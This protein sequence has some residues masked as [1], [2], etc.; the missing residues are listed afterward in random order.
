MVNVVKDYIPGWGF[1]EHVVED[2]LVA[3]RFHDP[4]CCYHCFLKLCV[5][6]FGQ[7]YSACN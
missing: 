6:S 5:A 7:I 4:R 1:G 3:I 2:C